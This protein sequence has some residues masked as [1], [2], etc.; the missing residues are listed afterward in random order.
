MGRSPW[1]AVKAIA[2]H[3]FERALAFQVWRLLW[4]E[5]GEVRVAT[6]GKALPTGNLTNYPPYLVGKVF[7]DV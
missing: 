2:H 3:R 4:P 7:T 5:V 6:L 1:T